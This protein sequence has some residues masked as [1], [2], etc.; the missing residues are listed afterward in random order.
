MSKPAIKHRGNKVGRFATGVFASA[1]A[2]GGL[3]LATGVAGAADAA[4]NGPGGLQPITDYA[5]YPPA[6]PDGCPDGAGALTDVS[7]DNGH[8]DV[9]DDLRKMPPPSVGDVITMSWSGF[10]P[11]CA[12]P[13]G[14]PLMTVALV[15]YHSQTFDFD[16]SQDQQLLSGWDACGPDGPACTQVDGRYQ[17]QLT[18]PNPGEP[19]YL[20]IDAI[21]DRPLAVIG[22]SGSTYNGS[23]RPPA[24][25]GQ[26]MLLS[27][28]NFGTECSVPDAHGARDAHR[29][30]DAHGPR[31]SDRQCDPDGHRD[32]HGARDPHCPAD[33]A[34]RGEPDRPRGGRVGD[35]R[36]SGPTAGDGGPGR[37]RDPASSSCRRPARPP[38]RGWPARLRR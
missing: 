29:P 11:G 8:G 7:Y 24:F 20:Q 26:T 33:A 1:L 36:R 2:L 16:P 21:L 35:R 17:L 13:D 4:P 12:G 27:A 30:R 22:P 31:D 14:S 10:A 3:G 9:V 23:L 6:L 18:V 34:R 37:G 38:R 32:T 19:C 25:E 5:N 15:A 28:M